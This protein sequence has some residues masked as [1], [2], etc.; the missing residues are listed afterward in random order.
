MSSI[1]S[2]DGTVIAFDRTGDGPP[3]ILVSGELRHRA[4][5]PRMAHLAELLTP[6][7]TVYHYD[8]RGRGQST[9][10]PAY[11]VDREIDDIDALIAHAGGPAQVFGMSSGAVLALDA[12][13][14]GLSI[15]RLALYEPPVVVDSTRQRVPHD[16][17]PRLSA[18]VAFGK[19]SDAVALFLTEF[20]GVPARQVSAMRDEAFWSGLETAAHTLPHDGAIMEGLVL[21]KPLPGSRW[22]RVTA[23]TLVID[24]EVSPKA[25]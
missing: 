20:V 12:A 3:V 1:R 16:Y 17:L 10:S 24:S 22:A 4:V 14:R 15:A 7:F 18:L 2:R 25:M 9:D 23:E 11:E 21:G 13:A 19:R 6:D 8:R 5:D